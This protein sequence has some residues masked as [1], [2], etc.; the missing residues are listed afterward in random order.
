MSRG[1]GDSFQKYCHVVAML[2][3]ESL[4]LVPDLVESP[5]AAEQYETLKNR[6]LASHQLTRY[7]RAERLF[8]MPEQGSSK[9]SDLMVAMLEVCPWAKRRQ[10]YWWR[11]QRAV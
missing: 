10:I 4:R 8:A 6:L 1:V 11:R 9:L 3:H 2:P 5:A 7:Q